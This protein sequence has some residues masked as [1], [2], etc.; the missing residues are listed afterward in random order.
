MRFADLPR[1]ARTYILGM[2]GLAIWLLLVRSELWSTG[3][4]SDVSAAQLALTPD[5]LIFAALALPATAAHAFPVGSLEKRQ[6]YHV[7]LPFFVAA[8]VLLPAWQLAVVMLVV[9]AAEWA[10]N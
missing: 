3:R 1:L 2:A 5:L 6:S 4:L 9:H 10:R 8:I 7:S